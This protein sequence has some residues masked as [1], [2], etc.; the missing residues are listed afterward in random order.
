MKN[1]IIILITSL[2]YSCAWRIILI[3]SLLYSCIGDTVN[4][5]VCA[6]YG[7]QRVITDTI[8]LHDNGRHVDIIISDKNTYTA[9][10]WG[11][12]TFFLKTPKWDD[13]TYRAVYN[14]TRKNNK[15]L[16]HVKKN[17]IKMDDWVAIPITEYQVD[18]LHKNIFASFNTDSTGTHQYVADGYG[19]N[20]TFY[21]ANGEYSFYYTCNTW[22]NEMLKNSNIYARK[23]AIFSDEVINIHN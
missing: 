10:G 18:S 5:Q 17:L 8:Y 23:H 6:I 15:V 1:I 20:D 19:S 11:S 12:E 3:A 16:M 13:L 2:L 22:A 21:K 4:H 14:A 9:Y 7:D